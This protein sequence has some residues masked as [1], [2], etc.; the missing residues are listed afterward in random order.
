MD[1]AGFVHTGSCRWGSCMD[2]HWKPHV[3]SPAGLG[4]E[5]RVDALVD[6]LRAIPD[7]DR[8][9]VEEQPLVIRGFGVC[10]EPLDE[11]MDLLL[12]NRMAYVYGTALRSQVGKNVYTA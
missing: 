12:P 10:P 3:I 9:L 2:D 8:T 7:L 6:Y 5:P 4:V 11:V 1:R